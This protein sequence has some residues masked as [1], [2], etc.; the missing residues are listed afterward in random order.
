LFLKLL[1]IEKHIIP[2]T[3]KNQPAFF[4]IMEL[5]V[6]T[7]QLIKQAELIYKQ[8]FPLTTCFERGMFYSWG[9]GIQDCAFCYMSTQPKDKNPKETKRSKESILAEFLLA[10]ELGWHIGFFTGG[11]GVFHP[12]EVEEFLKLITQVFGQKIWI[13][14]GALPKP[15]LIRY[16]PYLEGVVGSTETINLE[17]HKIIC[18]SK[19]LEPYQKMF[20]AAKELNMQTAMTLILGMGETKE[21]LELLKEFIRVHSISKIHIYGLKPREG[22]PLGNAPIPTA[23]WQ[24]WW[25]ASL[26]IA[27]PTL[28]IQCGIWED[29]LERVSLLLRAGA[30]AVSNFR[31]TKLFGTPLAHELEHQAVLAGRQFEGTLTVLPDI[32][33]DAKVTALNIDDQLKERIKEKIKQYLEVMQKNV[34]NSHSEKEVISIRSK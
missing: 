7:E 8:N 14:L 21:D 31:A 24:A 15:L 17:L 30:N 1:L 3:I 5:T 29:R 10:R 28:I 20:L 19:P 26:R 23:D 6:E 32:D 12:D 16:Q 33:W 11:I 25:I 9:C 22:T 4:S 18:P 2:R 34:N 13:S 27:F